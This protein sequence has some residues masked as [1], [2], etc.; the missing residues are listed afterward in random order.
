VTA[1]RIK[2]KGATADVDIPILDPVEI[3]P[4]SLQ[5]PELLGPLGSSSEM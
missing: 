4:R 3:S 2:E 5:A 1:R